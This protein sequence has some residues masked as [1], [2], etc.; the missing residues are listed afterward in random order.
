[1]KNKRIFALALAAFMM[2]STCLPYSGTGTVQA[3]T[4]YAQS[5]SVHSN[6]DKGD[7]ND[8][9]E[10][11]ADS[12]IAPKDQLNGDLDKGVIS[13]DK[14][15]PVDDKA[16]VK[17]E[18]SPS[19]GGVTQKGTATE[20]DRDSVKVDIHRENSDN[21]YLNESTVRDDD[22]V[23]VII[24][25]KGDSII[26][27]DSD[28]VLG[29]W[30]RFKS[31]YLEYK[32]NRVIKKIEDKALGGEKLDVKYHY[33]WL[34][35][36]I[37][38]QVPYG[39]IDEIEKISGV[40][41]VILQPVYEVCSDEEKKSSVAKPYT[42]IDGEM[43]GREQT[44]AGGYSGKGIKIAIV[45][46]GIDEDHQS[47]APL[48]SDQLTENSADESTIA[49]VLDNLNA[50]QI[51]EGLDASKV[52]YNTKIAYGFNYVDNSLV[53]NHSRDEQG[54]HGTHVAG[55]AA[56]NDLGDGGVVGVAPE[57]QLYV[58]KVFGQA[59]G[60]YTEDIV[61]ALEDAL[62]L[63]AD[64]V[65]MSLGGPAGFTSSAD[66]VNE[67]YNK[68]A[69]TNTYLAVAAGNSTTFGLGNLWGTDT[70]LASNP[71]NGIVS[72]PST[73]SNATSVASVNNIG[74]YGYYVEINGKRYSYSDGS[75]TNPS[76]ITLAG[77][78]YEYVM[79]G[80][81]GKEAE[82]F[83]GVE[84]KIAVVSRGETTFAA[85][86]ELA[87]AAGAIACIIYNNVDGDF[88]MDLSTSN[89][90]TIPSVSVTKEAGEFLASVLAED[91]AAKLL[92][93]SEPAFV[94][95]PLAY[96]MS[97]F[98]SWGV[99]PNLKLE[100]EVT[101]PGGNIFSTL[102]NGAYG[103]MSGTSMACPNVAGVAALVMQY[104][105]AQYPDMSA[106]ELH[107]FVNRLIM[108]T[109][110]PLL[111]DD[112]LTYSPR[113]QGA[114]LVNAFSAVRSSAYLSVNGLDMP[115]IELGD[116]AAKTGKYKYTFN[117]VNF[118]TTDNYYSIFTNAQTE[119]VAEYEDIK[120]MAT[121]PIALDALTSW[122]SK[123]NAVKVYDYTDDGLFDTA[124][125]YKLFQTVKSEYDGNDRFR[126][127]LTGDDGVDEAD[128][129][130]Y[131]DALVGKPDASVD[132]DAEMLKV[133]AGSTAV[134]EVEVD[135]A[136][137]GKKFM[138]DNFENGIYVEGF[139]VL[140]GL[141]EGTVQLSIPYL[142][143]YG[144]WT[145]APIIDTGDFWLKEEDVIAS[146]YYNVLWST[147]GGSE[148]V[149][150]TNPYIEIDGIDL[151]DI[152]LSPDGDGFVDTI[153]DIYISLLR[154]AR[155]LNVSY[156]IGDEVFDTVTIANVPKS[157]L[158]E[159]AGICIPYV[160][161]FET[162][163]LDFSSLPDNTKID[164]VVKATLDYDKHESDNLRDTWSVPIVIDRTRPVLDEDK[165]I[166]T[167]E[168]GRTYVTLTFADNV[169]VA[170]VVFISESETTI[171]SSNLPAER[172]TLDAPCTQTFDVTGFGDSFAV[173][174][175]DYACNES[176]YYLET[177]DNMPVLDES[178][179]YGYRVYADEIY[180][181]TLYG[182]VTLD[183]ATG[184]MVVLDSEYYVDYSV[185]A[186]ESVGGYI[187]AQL[188]SND[189]VAIVPG[190][191]DN[192]IPIASADV[193]FRDMAFDE[194]TKTLYGVGDGK[195]Y[196]V[197]IFTGE[198]TTVT[199]FMDYMMPEA[200]TMAAA[201]DGTLYGVDMMGELHVINKETGT[202][203]DLV[204]NTSEI[205]G[206][207]PSYQQ[208]M[209]YVKEENAIYWPAFMGINAD[210]YRIDLDDVT[211]IK[212]GSIEGNAELVGVCTLDAKG[213][214]FPEVSP[215][216]LVLN[217][218]SI[219]LGVG[220]EVKLNAKCAPW[221][222]KAGGYVWTSDD[223]SVAT[224]S[225]RG[226]V[227]AV[228]LGD[229]VITVTTEDGTVS[230]ECKVSVLDPHSEFYAF[231]IGSANLYNQWIKADTDNLANPEILSSEGYVSYFAGEYVDGNIYSFSS[232]SELYKTNLETMET[233][234]ISTGSADY[235]VV[236][237]AYNYADGYLYALVQ[238]N[239]WG[240]MQL[241]VVDTLT[242]YI[243]FVDQFFMTPDDAVPVTMAISTEGTMYLIAD[244]GMLYTY[245]LYEGWAVVGSTGY[246]PAA[247]TQTMAY[248]HNNGGLY[249]AM[250][251]A[252][253][254]S[255]VMYVDPESGS[256]IPVGS[257]DGG[258]QT[259]GMFMI[260]ETVPEREEVPVEE[261]VPMVDKLSILVGSSAGIP[262]L[263]Y[264]FNATDRSVTWTIEDTSIAE[265]VDGVVYGKA[266]GETVIIG[267]KGDLE[268]SIP[269]VV[270][271]SAGEIRGYILIDY[272][273]NASD[274]WGKFDD[275]KLS[276]GGAALSD[277]SDYQIYAAEYFNGKIY[278][279]GVD[280][281]TNE[282]VF[283]TLD[284]ENYT[285]TNVVYGNFPDMKDMA[286]DYSTG[287][288]YGI[289]GVRNVSNSGSLYAIDLK[290]GQCYSIGKLED[291]LL[292]LACSTDGVLYG[293]S[294]YG[295][296]YEISKEDG[297]LMPIGD[298]G[299]MANQ[300]Q[301]MAYDHNTGNLYWAQNYNDMLSWT[302]TANLL[303][304]DPSD[305]STI[306]LGKIGVYGSEVTGLHTV[307][308]QEMTP[309]VPEI[310][311]IVL[312]AEKKLL[313]PGDTFTVE[314]SAMPLSAYRDD[315]T[316]TFASS[317]SSVA[318]VDAYGVVTGVAAGTAV[319]TV[320]CGT[321]SSECKVTVCDNKSL[322][323][324]VNAAGW[325][326][327]GLLYPEKIESSVTFPMTSGFI[328]TT[329]DYSE[330]D[331]CFYGIDEDGYLWKYTLDL[332]EI[333]RL[334]ETPL[335][336]NLDA[337]LLG[338]DLS[339]FDRSI[340]DITFN[341][342]NG[343]CYVLVRVKMDWSST[344]MIFEVDTQSAT[345]S[346]VARIDEYTVKRA[347]EFVCI[348]E[349]VFMIHDGYDDYIY[350]F[351]LNTQMPVPFVW[352][353]GVFAAGDLYGMVYSKEHD[354]VFAST[355][356][357][358][359]NSDG[360]M[361]YYIIDPSGASVS[362]YG[363]AAY[364]KG[365]FDLVLIE[366][367]GE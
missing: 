89:I 342:F 30:T 201:A 309:V 4:E 93:A 69:E 282:S 26:D 149:P 223:E 290:N 173:V 211:M 34:V 85:K 320:T 323:Y 351:D 329:V 90:I 239:L 203:G 48:T 271:S 253:G 229:T 312:N 132:F 247:Y 318:T 328:P 66:W 152:S 19:G 230:A 350:T 148:W 333:V 67:V 260:P 186:A 356:D 15:K 33:T 155:E 18:A 146:Q 159:N 359:Y 194:T 57:A 150:G 102:D 75:G 20:L 3:K 315:V 252:A 169:N 142:G 326:T 224:V 234:R 21:R 324:A 157:Y 22:M 331:G 64:V 29:F 219:S 83:A 109:A 45:D 208:S 115:K 325:E 56:A 133:P 32:Q 353:Q 175:G 215:E 321:I 147:A 185:T 35:N 145:K 51:Y 272:E 8:K 187:I 55:I 52:Y 191:W 244:N 111:Y 196:A 322:I 135:V 61:A 49:G 340:L 121:T 127:E 2:V 41:R 197:D 306:N 275:S 99:T 254:D 123:D 299:Y 9:K 292:T 303:V 249:W 232:A 124:D 31:N 241:G 236:D 178:L 105:K 300:Y 6:V 42:V 129:Q 248:D 354:V 107:L 362:R 281:M 104:A 36:G 296:L 76:F 358:G 291:E 117:V 119:D 112:V 228:G 182:W 190:M 257:I 13:G 314:A 170:G 58:M 307:P 68:V 62:I 364:N 289:G 46:T 106:S 172:A 200:V 278:G 136:D 242:G 24:V 162:T 131:L 240:V 122:S 95:S 97:D 267:T 151:R 12:K 137:S 297:S 220:S 304:V 231:V 258:A 276:A 91:P 108:S 335:V 96:K 163:P 341:D 165:V 128:V 179:L 343:K 50:A 103:L 118:G 160:H 337:S 217:R 88:G 327:S 153:T 360:S 195:L 86:T 154:N 184:E 1:M 259:V 16:S 110:T 308:K 168:D 251:S 214:T 43:I 210:L 255:A 38:T 363:T 82:D 205:T 139:T 305:A 338:M 53:I 5:G 138:D 263:V 79:V 311:K 269:V 212:V 344:N 181:D 225:R 274:F 202:W 140:S 266:A 366:G 355:I 287:T 310:T 73:Y 336:E 23:R 101:A 164:L 288:M 301:S 348:S 198:V 367:A 80:N 227:T 250:I 285:T 286:F 347:V 27:S 245:S 207:F 302:T 77:E 134:V 180:D 188:A 37:A 116:D 81:C 126:Y 237:M 63:G 193:S 141:S 298:T 280:F 60:A 222:A 357:V 349:D 113:S 72:Q 265:L 273:T 100:P 209:T 334:G 235:L 171:Y 7:K 345:A 339:T 256:T 268:V 246:Y 294:E 316:Y 213:V 262:A 238:N 330:E 293:V 361:G 54:D 270:I 130:L 167:K 218:T 114:G 65:N 243:E 84:G 221:Y 74:V 176:V 40:E 78:S 174:L 70:N 199:D 47:F 17:G 59:G 125:A 11:P 183:P 332:S 233:A 261:I 10:N 192:R 28:A 352:A 92:V 216:S 161:S 25:M 279:Y 14:T 158:N 206:G 87:Q 346:Y 284:A 317:D 277:M 44:W 71:D 156:M 204:L 365:M 143:F 189:I 319:I 39:M 94:P 226:L 120:F 144:D 264:P 166:F 177:E 98:S 295:M 313:R 283:V